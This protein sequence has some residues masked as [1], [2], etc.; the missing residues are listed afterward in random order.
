MTDYTEQQR[1]RWSIHVRLE[2]E[3]KY[4]TEGIDEAIFEDAG[5]FNYREGAAINWTN[6]QVAADFLR[7]M[8]DEIESGEMS[9]GAL[10]PS[11]PRPSANADAA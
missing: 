10:G 1:G 5:S 2:I 11:I 9:E 8:A 4:E 7:A 6:R 3:P